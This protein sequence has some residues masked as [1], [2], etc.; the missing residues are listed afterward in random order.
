[1]N[2]KDE[3]IWKTD[4][5]PFLAGSVRDCILQRGKNNGWGNRG[6]RCFMLRFIREANG[7]WKEPGISFY[8]LKKGKQKKS[9]MSV[10]A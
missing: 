8:I 5:G 7:A 2:T 3:K 4:S 9:A 10:I 6:Q 1:M